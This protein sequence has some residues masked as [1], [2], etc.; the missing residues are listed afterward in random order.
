MIISQDRL[1]VASHFCCTLKSVFT[2]IFLV[3][4]A[5]VFGCHTKNR[6]EFPQPP[7]VFLQYEMCCGIAG[8]QTFQDCFKFIT[9][10]YSNCSFIH[11]KRCGKT[12]RQTG[13]LFCTKKGRVTTLQMAFT[14]N[15]KPFKKPYQFLKDARAYL[16]KRTYA[17]PLNLQSCSSSN[18]LSFF[19]R[20][21]NLGARVNRP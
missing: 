2:W 17:T 18:Q 7:S 1:F 20:T 15:K 21:D 12:A 9:F 11:V 10:H 4:L 6:L 3:P 5:A 8:K 19:V 16:R 13:T 14:Y